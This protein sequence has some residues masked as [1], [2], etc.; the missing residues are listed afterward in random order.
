MMKPSHLFLTAFGIASLG[1]AHADPIQ[2]SEFV[3]EPGE[4]WED[5]TSGRPMRAAELKF[6]AEGDEDPVAV[7]YHFGAGQ[8]GGIDANVRRW[9][10]QFEGGPEEVE[11]EELENGGLLLFLKGTYLES[12]GG[13]FAE[14]K[15]PKENYRM[16]AAILPS[17]QGSVYVKLTAPA[18]VADEARDAFV[19]LVKSGLE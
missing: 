18:E 5:V 15:V 4:Q 3:F 10:G 17:D 14:P 12:M 11:Q 2:V 7:F 8:G 13:P 16:L 9:K 6:D 19:A 1:L